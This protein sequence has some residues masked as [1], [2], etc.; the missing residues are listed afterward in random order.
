MFLPESFHEV[1][2]VHMAKVRG[3]GAVAKVIRGKGF[4][5]GK[6]YGKTHSSRFALNLCHGFATE[7]FAITFA[8]TFAT[9]TF[10]ITFA[11]CTCGT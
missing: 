9:G 8:T 7:T 3:K 4:F 2:Q 5:R 1:P 6:C 11:I 10:A